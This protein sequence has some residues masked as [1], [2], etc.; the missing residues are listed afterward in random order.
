MVA[1]S[2]TAPVAVAAIEDVDAAVAE[3]V[4]P[5]GDTLAVQAVTLVSKSGDQ[6]PMRALCAVVVV[7]GL[8]TGNPRLA[9]AGLRMLA[10]HTIATAA[11]NALKRRIDRTRP[12]ARQHEH[13][14]RIRPGN[15]VS[16][17]E[18]S[19]H[20]G[21]SAGAMAVGAAFAR[22]FP[23][24]GG[25]ALGAAGAV[26]LAQVPRR[27]HYLSDVVVGSAIGL[28]SEAALNRLISGF[29]IRDR[30]RRGH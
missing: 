9:G 22:A 15:S 2:A 13:D 24:H 19:F 27:S 6:P 21:H 8:V 29:G 23:D 10:A 16:H 20:S 18:T 11:K 3:K 30:H 5:R 14:H 28:I 17:D 7:G 4:G 1:K 12:D 26:A 25:S